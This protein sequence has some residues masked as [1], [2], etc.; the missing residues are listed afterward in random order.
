MEDWWGSN[1]ETCLTCLNLTSSG[2]FNTS[3]NLAYF[4]PNLGYDRGR[5]R[6][7]SWPVDDGIILMGG[8]DGYDNTKLVRFDG[9]SEDAFNL[10]YSTM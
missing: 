9:T 1:C 7:S 4:N 5:W 6:H 3:H 2:W 8:Y 10:T